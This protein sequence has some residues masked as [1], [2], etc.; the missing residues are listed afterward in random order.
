[1]ERFLGNSWFIHNKLGPRFFP[2]HPSRKEFFVS[3]HANVRRKA[4]G[5][6]GA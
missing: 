6:Y 3:D 5:A 4:A 1:M 2:D